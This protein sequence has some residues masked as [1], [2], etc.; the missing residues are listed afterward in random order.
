MNSST[1]STEQI[2]EP[3]R[4]NFAVFRKGRTG[5]KVGRPAG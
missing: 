5:S 1:I 4:E 3:D 2:A